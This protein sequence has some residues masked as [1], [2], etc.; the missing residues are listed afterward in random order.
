MKKGKRSFVPKKKYTF[1]KPLTK[2]MSSEFNGGESLTFSSHIS[3][4]SLEENLEK[5][6]LSSM[7]TIK[8]WIKLQY[9]I[10]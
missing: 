3:L 8:E 4:I 9:N 7:S 6:N 1:A 5:V 10:H 2:S